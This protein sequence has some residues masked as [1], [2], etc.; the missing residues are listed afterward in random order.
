[1]HACIRTCMIL[2]VRRGRLSGTP[3]LAVLCWPALTADLFTARTGYS[4]N[5]RP[6]SP[7]QSLSWVV[8]RLRRSQQA[9]CVH[10]QE[11]LA[12]EFTG[13]SL[14]LTFS[15]PQFF[16]HLTTAYDILRH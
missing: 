2:T 11:W 13:R 15:V 7:P 10:L 5:S 1:M 14:L 3:L 6:V 9:N 12:R 4:R 8:W 16:F